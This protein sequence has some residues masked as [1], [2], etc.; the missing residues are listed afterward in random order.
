MWKLRI[1]ILVTS[2][3]FALGLSSAAWATRGVGDPFLRCQ[4]GGADCIVSSPAITDVA[5]AVK[6]S[7]G[8]ITASRTRPSRKTRKHREPVN[9]RHGK[10]RGRH[11]KA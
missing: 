4:Q 2:G 9:S 3:V 6:T 8:A 10:L 7:I 5:G 11:I 1:G